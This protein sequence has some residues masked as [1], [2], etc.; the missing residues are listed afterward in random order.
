MI[1]Y[2]APLCTNGTAI[3]FIFEYDCLTSTPSILKAGIRDLLKVVRCVARI[4]I[5]SYYSSW[6]I[7][8][9]QLVIHYYPESRSARRCGFGN[10]GKPARLGIRRDGGK[11]PCVGR[12]KLTYGDA[13]SGGGARNEERWIGIL[14]DDLCLSFTQR[15]ARI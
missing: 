3:T 6:Q 2:F 8:L 13:I 4:R 10:G 9:G 1:Y 7:T 5:K 15:D 11:G 14:S 12:F